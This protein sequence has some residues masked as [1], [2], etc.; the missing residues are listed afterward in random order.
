MRPVL[1]CLAVAAVLGGS[2][3]S[4][5]PEI[6]IAAGP[7]GTRVASA[8]GAIPP[9]EIR[10][11]LLFASAEATLETGGR[12]FRVMGAVQHGSTPN[13]DSPY[14]PPPP[15]V[16]GASSSLREGDLVFATDPGPA[17]GQDVRD[18]VVVVISSRS[19]LRS[20]LS[21][22]ARRQLELFKLAAK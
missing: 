22:P 20:R 14:S 1:A 21:D 19:E 4:N 15:D 10:N 2:A 16:A 13:A 5:S 12:F 17:D 18:A 8:R 6:A 9:H 11:A 7:N 3:C